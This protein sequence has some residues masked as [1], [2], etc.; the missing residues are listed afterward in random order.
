MISFKEFLKEKL[1]DY[2]IMPFPKHEHKDIKKRLNRTGKLITLRVSRE[3]NKYKEGQVVKTEW[4]DILKV[5]KIKRLKSIEKYPY[6][7]E[8]RPKDIKLLKKYDNIDWIT[9]I[10]VK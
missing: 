2:V 6:I 10:V 3:L 7:S 9:L 8:I 4:G 1:N 5:I